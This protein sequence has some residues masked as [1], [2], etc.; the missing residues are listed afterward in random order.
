[1]LRYATR[2][3]RSLLVCVEFN[4]LSNALGF[5]SIG[6]ILGLSEI[7]IVSRVGPRTEG[8]KFLDQ[9]RPQP[10]SRLCHRLVLT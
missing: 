10:V 8:V 7:C 6:P 9:G 2:P 4:S 3:T 5:K 1:V